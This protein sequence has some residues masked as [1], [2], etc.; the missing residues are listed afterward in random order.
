MSAVHDLLFN[1]ISATFYILRP[2]RYGLDSSGSGE[3]LVE[4]S[5]ELGTE[6]SVP[7]KCWEFLG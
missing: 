7:I 1:I 6:S 5:R 3:R 4:G 2:L